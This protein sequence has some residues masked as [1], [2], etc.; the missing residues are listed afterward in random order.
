MQIVEYFQFHLRHVLVT[1]QLSN[2]YVS[3]C[4][5]VSAWTGACC[6][7]IGLKKMRQK[8]QKVDCIVEVHDARISSL[9]LHYN[10]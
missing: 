3:L 2:D 1:E 4:T 8:L 7:C 10:N 6:K 5:L 9:Y